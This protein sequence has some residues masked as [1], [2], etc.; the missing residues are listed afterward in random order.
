M[1]GLNGKELCAR[2]CS[3]EED[4]SGLA[5]NFVGLNP[6]HEEELAGKC[7]A[8]DGPGEQGHVQDLDLGAMWQPH[9][10][11]HMPCMSSS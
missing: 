8:V 9:P 6:I 1:D 4:C 10:S 7:F 11:P 3:L 5:S 2:R